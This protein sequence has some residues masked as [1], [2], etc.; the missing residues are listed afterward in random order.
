M[1]TFASIITPID[2]EMSTSGKRKSRD[3]NVD[4]N[5]KKRMM[6]EEPTLTGQLPQEEISK[7][8]MPIQSQMDSIWD[9]MMKVV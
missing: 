7:I 3:E 1:T 5:F 6:D 9:H 4:Q 2:Y 8:L